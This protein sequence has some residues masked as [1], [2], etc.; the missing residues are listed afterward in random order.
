MRQHRGTTLERWHY[1][2]VDIDAVFGPFT[3]KAAY[4]LSWEKHLT[5]VDV[6]WITCWADDI[7]VSKNG[8]ADKRSAGW[9]IF[10]QVYDVGEQYPTA[11]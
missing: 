6:P 10:K 1:K 9:Y 3:K 11:T 2:G 7:P 4:C 5:E 8:G